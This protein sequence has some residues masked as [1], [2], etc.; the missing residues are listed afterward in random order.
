MTLW[1]PWSLF[2]YTFFKLKILKESFVFVRTIEMQFSKTNDKN[3]K[4]KQIKNVKLFFFVILFSKLLVLRKNIFNY[5]KV[6]L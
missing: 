4:R 3:I 5:K 1:Q 6:I 2:S